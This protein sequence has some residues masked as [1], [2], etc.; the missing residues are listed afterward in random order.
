LFWLI[1]FFYKLEMIFH[2]PR[3]LFLAFVNEW[4]YLEDICRIDSALCCHKLRN[5]YLTKL[6][7][8]PKSINILG[9]DLNKLRNIQLYRWLKNKKLTVS[10]I[11]LKKKNRSP[12]MLGLCAEFLH[13][14]S[15]SNLFSDILLNKDYKYHHNII[16]LAMDMK[17]FESSKLFNLFVKSGDFSKLT[18]IHLIFD[19]PKI[20]LFDVPSLFRA[21]AN[22]LTCVRLINLQ[23]NFVE[24]ME[25][26]FTHCERVRELDLSSEIN[27]HQYKY[28]SGC[29]FTSTDIKCRL[30]LT[31]LETL[32]CNNLNIKQTNVIFNGILNELN[33]CNLKHLIVKNNSNF[34]SLIYFFNQPM[35]VWIN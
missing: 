16:S 30:V 19:T 15:P 24:L 35:Q 21:C 18:K 13:L 27:K 10:F 25:C 8:F 1:S 14:L 11:S 22:T 20:L 7:S 2:L 3:Y 4:I 34:H 32:T 17:I 26:L 33:Q 29:W 28:Q 9:S 31:E 5:D 6:S 23:L 12:K